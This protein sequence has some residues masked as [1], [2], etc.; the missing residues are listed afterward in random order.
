MKKFIY[1]LLCAATLLTSCDKWP[2]NGKLDGMWQLT[3]IATD[4]GEAVSTTGDGI[5]W[6]VQLDLI[7]IHTTHAPLNGSTFD[8]SVTFEYQGDAL[9]L[10]GLYIHEF[11]GDELITDPASTAL[12]WTGIYGTGASFHIARLDSK[13]MILENER[14]RLV[15][16]KMG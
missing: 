11:T 12:A 14:V 2:E 16:R 5:F 10:T 7:V 13:R 15:F 9:N 3:S 6:K 4:G 1:I 8:T